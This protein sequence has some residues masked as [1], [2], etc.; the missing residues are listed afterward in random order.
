MKKIIICIPSSYYEK[1]LKFNAFQLLEK[2]Y[3]VIYVINKDKFDNLSLFK[4]KKKFF[5][6][7]NK[8]DDVKYLKAIHLSMIFN[9]NRCK[10]L[11]YQFMQQY[12][13][14]FDYIKINRQ[15]NFELNKKNGLLALVTNTIKYFSRLFFRRLRIIFLS[16]KPVYPL[17]KKLIIDKFKLDNDL[18]K[19]F[20]KIN[21]D[22]TI[23]PSHCLEPESIKLVKISKF[24]KSKILFLVDNWDNISSKTI[25]IE[26]PDAISV[27]G[28]QT[29]KHANLIQKIN[30]KKIF[31]LGS[32]KFDNYIQLKKK[33]LSRIIN[34]PYVIFIGIIKPYNEIDALKKLDNEISKNRKI[35]KNLKVLYRPHPG[36]EHLIRL[37]SKSNLR[38][39]I[40]DPNMSKSDISS[41]WTCPKIPGD[42]IFQ[43]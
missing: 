26:K 41:K 35:Y 25:F 20:Q 17:F 10:T 16:S 4:N 42:V 22:I 43:K 5:Y 32:P 11:K 38:N 36:R 8:K 33:K 14:Y 34:D 7:S 40:F 29:V 23:Y 37:A 1:Y 28:D 12:P 31:K 30:K 27:W 19:I 15:K 39:I 3:E 13:D 18:K 21:P 24:L 9:K 6:N 2:N